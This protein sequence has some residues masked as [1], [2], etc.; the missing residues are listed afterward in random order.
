LHLPLPRGGR[1]SS[2]CLHSPVPP[3]KPISTNDT[4]NLQCGKRSASRRAPRSCYLLYR[5]RVLTVAGR[6]G[7]RKRWHKR[8]PDSGSRNRWLLRPCRCTAVMAFPQPTIAG[9]WSQGGVNPGQ[10]PRPSHGETWGK[11]DADAHKTTPLVK[12]YEGQRS[13]CVGLGAMWSSTR[14]PFYCTTKGA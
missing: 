2:A 5:G 8:L 10:A 11:P 1:G 12:W 7:R 4:E 13:K 14:P 6:E 9:L 3:Q